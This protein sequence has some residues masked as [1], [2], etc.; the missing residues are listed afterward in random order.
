MREKKAGKHEALL[1]SLDDKENNQ[2]AFD[3]DDEPPTHRLTNSPSG[4]FGSWRGVSSNELVR[5][6]YRT[7]TEKTCFVVIIP[8]TSSIALL[9]TRQLL[10]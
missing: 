10:I 4:L 7:P 6:F 8:I 5:P 2:S 3:D 9:A 1:Q